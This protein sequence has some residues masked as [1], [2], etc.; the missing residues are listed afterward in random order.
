VCIIQLL[1]AGMEDTSYLEFSRSR[2]PLQ[3]HKVDDEIVAD[4]Q[5]QPIRGVLRHQYLPCGVRA[6]RKID[7]VPINQCSPEELLIVTAINPLEQYTFYFIVYV[8]DTGFGCKMA[9]VGYTRYR[10]E[11]AYLRCGKCYGLGFIGLV[12]VI[13]AQG[14]IAK[15]AALLGRDLALNAFQH[16]DGKHHGRAAQRN[17]AYGNTDNQAGEGPFAGHRNPVR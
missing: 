9:Y 7:R 11:L 12:E 6:V 4:G 14:D 2:P 5:V 3:L 13:I 8:D 17:G 15:K 10:L 16:G 1:H